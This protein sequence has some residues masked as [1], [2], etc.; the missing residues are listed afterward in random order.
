MD[1]ITGSIVAI[2][3]VLTS[4]FLPCAFLTGITGQFYRQ[5][6]LTISSAMIIS[7]I[8]A[9]TLTPSRA[10][11]VFKTETKEG[12][13]HEHVREALPWWIFVI[14][15][16]LVSVVYLQTPVADYFHLPLGDAAVGAHFPEVVA[17]RGVRRGISARRHCVWALPVGF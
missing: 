7:A 6:A 10:V 4:V 1:E 3:L 17:V 12:G 16:G 15:G 13:G 9:M 14:I 8:N 11:S 2:T 5:F